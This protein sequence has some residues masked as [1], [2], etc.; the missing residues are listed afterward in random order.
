MA[1]LESVGLYVV[2][3]ASLEFFLNLCRMENTTQ[4]FLQ[5]PFIFSYQ[6]KTNPLSQVHGE[7]L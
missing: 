2:Y 5:I 6:L 1:V 3:A 7:V 4:F